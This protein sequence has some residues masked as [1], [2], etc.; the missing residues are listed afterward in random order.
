MIAKKKSTL[1]FMDFYVRKKKK[2]IVE[3]KEAMGEEN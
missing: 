3:S 2:T 1:F